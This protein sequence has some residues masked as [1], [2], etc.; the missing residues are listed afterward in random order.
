MPGQSERLDLALVRRGLV[1]TRARAR[2]LILRGQ[3]SVDGLIVLKPAANVGSGSDLSIAENAAGDVSRG[4]VKLRAALDAFA[5]SAAG[6]V[7]LDIGASTGGF[8]QTL[9]GAGAAKVYA[10][11]VGQAQLA[12]AL[13][14]DGRV[15]C[16]EKQDA[17]T[18]SR[19]EIGE[20]IQAIV[21]DVSFISLI[22][23]LPVPLGFAAPAAW[24]VALIKPQF[25]AGREA[26]G[27]GGVVRDASARAAAVDAVADWLARQPGWSVV[28]VVVSPIAGGDGNAEFLIGARFRG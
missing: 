6:C 18:L 9:L 11:D 26:V 19:A 24:L 21:A 14:G 15:V 22:N 8:T 1:S 16:L 13:R 7:C 23:A 28:G 25:E 3:V 27:K 12:A 10:V 4:A 20:P 5:F 17:R 2:D